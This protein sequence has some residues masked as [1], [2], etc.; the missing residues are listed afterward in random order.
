MF[1]QFST[2]FFNYPQLFSFQSNYTPITN[3]LLKHLFRRLSIFF[4]KYF[5]D[6]SKAV[7]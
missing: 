5:F 3:I 7:F 2:K 1:F 6:S 4:L